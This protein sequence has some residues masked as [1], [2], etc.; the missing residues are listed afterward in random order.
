MTT[1]MQSQVFFFI[2]S[3][4]FILLGILSVV[5]LIYLIYLLNLFSRILKIIEKDINS[6]GD[7]TKDM[8]YEIRDSNI[9]RFVFGH[10]HR[11]INNNR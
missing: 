2:S 11:R 10:K 1:I 4:G 3:I 5:I 7:T 6:I 8:I 9:Y